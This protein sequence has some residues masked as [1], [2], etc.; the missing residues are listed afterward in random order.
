MPL[1][2]AAALAAP[3]SAGAATTDSRALALAK[4]AAA[5]LGTTLS[6]AEGSALASGNVS[7]VTTFPGTYAGIA[8]MPGGKRAIASG[9]D[10]V[11]SL[12]ISDP[13]SPKLESFQPLPHFE[14]E[15]IQ[16]DG[17]IALVSNDREK[18]SIGGVLYILDVSKPQISLLSTLNISDPQNND[19]G[20]GHIANCVKDGC[21][22]VYLTGG[23]DV[24]VADLR[25]P[26]SPKLVGKFTTP[27]SAGSSGFGT[28]GKLR[29]GAVHEADRDDAGRV[30]LTGSGGIAVYDVSKNP[31]KPTLLATSG[32]AGTDP[33]VNDFIEHN[34]KHPDAR[35]YSA[36]GPRSAGGPLR[37]GELLLAT[38]EDYTD[39]KYPGSACKGQGKFQT[40]DVRDHTKGRTFTLLDQWH[41]E[42]AAAK[43][44][45]GIK[46]PVSAMCSSHWFN[47]RKGLVADAWYE[48]GLRVLDVSN[49][50]KIRQ[51][52]YYMA[53]NSLTWAGY[54]VTDS[55]IY[56]ADVGRGIDVIKIDRGTSTTSLPTVVAPVRASWLGAAP[57]L[58]RVKASS[59]WG[60]ACGDLVA[61]AH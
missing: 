27:T 53:P 28:K 60:W 36:R 1:I 49:P 11:T 17:K 20:P 50:K 61:A 4:D 13:E 37:A 43:D 33:K 8:V 57:R 48:Q 19:R 55:I 40:W 47:Y 31:A 22:W 44:V 42:L 30:W 29:T 32:K 18:G 15:D 58:D 38:E 2:A 51:V 23:L 7:L 21:S 6:T 34:S 14:N 5:R 54:W 12:D 16:T 26:A 41:T 35:S 3:L 56:T 46:A 24:Y 39:T 9:W 59:R 25:E 52:G 45:G 10:G